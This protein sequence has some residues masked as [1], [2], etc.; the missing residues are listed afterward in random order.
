M[1]WC[2]VRNTSLPELIITNIKTR[3]CISFVQDIN[4]KIAIESWR[5]WNRNIGGKLFCIMTDNAMAPSV[6]RSSVAIALIVCHYSDII[7][8][9]IASQI[10]SL[11]IVYSTVYSDADKRKHQGSASLALVRGIQQWPMNSPPQMASNTENVSIW[12]RHHEIRSSVACIRNSCDNTCP[13]DVGI[14]WNGRYI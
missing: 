4:A 5:C 8:G 2:C 7:M 6:A 14:P 9:A 10:T 12:W 11:T 1:A 3:Y 13:S